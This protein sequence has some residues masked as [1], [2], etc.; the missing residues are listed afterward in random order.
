MDMQSHPLAD[1]GKDWDADGMESCLRLMLLEQSRKLLSSYLTS[2]TFSP[3]EK[4]EYAW[5]IHCCSYFRLD[6][7]WELR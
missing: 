1:Y 6:L 5:W 3:V 7:L 2:L 4:F